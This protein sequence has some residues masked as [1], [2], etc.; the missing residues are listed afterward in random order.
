MDNSELLLRRRLA[1]LVQ[2]KMARHFLACRS[3]FKERQSLFGSCGNRQLTT[4]V[5]GMAVCAE[6]DTAVTVRV[7]VPGGVPPPL[8]PLVVVPVLPEQPVKMSKQSVDRANV[9]RG[10]GQRLELQAVTS[11]QN[12]AKPMSESHKMRSKWGPAIK[13]NPIA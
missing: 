8:L 3:I 7:D 4:S 5:S 13:G 10:L 9:R 11:H 12:A 2:Q 6:P 1:R